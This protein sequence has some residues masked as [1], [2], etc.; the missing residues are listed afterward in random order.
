MGP[1]AVSRT[2][3][4]RSTRPPPR[5][6]QA[7]AQLHQHRILA[8]AERLDGLPSLQ[9]LAPGLGRIAYPHQLDLGDHQGIRGR[10]HEAAA[11]PAELGGVADRGHHR[12][13]LAGHGHQDFAPVDDHIGGDAQ[14]QGE[15]ADHVLHQPVGQFEG[16]VAGVPEPRQGLGFQR[17]D[18]GH[19]LQPLVMAESAKSSDARGSDIHDCGEFPFFPWPVT[20][21]PPRSP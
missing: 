21:R 12:G 9:D 17:R 20:A 1:P 7:A 3:T 16:Q 18:P 10:G 14:R 19:R 11:G 2:R 15:G 4:S 8:V 13:L 5:I 6:D